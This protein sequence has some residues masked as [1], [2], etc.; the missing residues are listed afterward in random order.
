MQ[1]D[2]FPSEKNFVTEPQVEVESLTPI[3]HTYLEQR[4]REARALIDSQANTL[5]SYKKELESRMS[6]TEEVLSVISEFERKGDFVSAELFRDILLEK[7]ILPFPAQESVTTIS[8]ELKEQRKSDARREINRADAEDIEFLKE[9]AIRVL[10]KN[11]PQMYLDQLESEGKF[12]K[13]EI[14]RMAFIEKGLFHCEDDKEHLEYI[15]QIKA[16]ILNCNE[17]PRRTVNRLHHEGRIEE[18]HIMAEVL[19][20]PEIQRKLA[21]IGIGRDLI[22]DIRSNCMILEGLKDATSYDDNQRQI[23]ATT[24]VI[25]EQFSLLKKYLKDE[26]FSFTQIGSRPSEIDAIEHSL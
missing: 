12:L 22:K 6:N 7:K 20:N 3:E 16:F 18:A 5:V 24:A 11:D 4:R 14:A 26:K 9:Q 8:A 1:L 13:A 17:D 19:K 2:V 21:N 25:K 15:E 23:E 10:G